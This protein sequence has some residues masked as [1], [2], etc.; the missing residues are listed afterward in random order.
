MLGWLDRRLHTA[1]ERHLSAA[2][3]E[4]P[5]HVAVI[6]DGNRRY[7]RK[8][9]E[10]PEAG[11]HAGA[12]TTEDMLS[13]CREV[14]VE[15]LTFYAFSTENFD[16]PPAQREALFDLFETKLREFADADRVHEEGVC[17]RGIGER[18]RLPTRV[19]AALRYAESRTEDYDRFTL[20]VALAYG[21]RSAM[22]SAARTVASDVAEGAI[23]PSE[24]DVE[25]V[26]ERLYDRPLRDVDLIVRTGG[27]ERT[28][29]FLP[30][31]A[32]GNE[33][34][35]YFCA[36]YWPEFSRI[37]FLR[38]L[39]TYEAREASWRRDR[40]RRALALL[41]AVGDAE[42]AEA[43]SILAR[44]RDAVPGDELPVG[45]RDVDSGE[46]SEPDP[47]AD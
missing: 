40:A 4:P 5:T 24:V 39:R 38:G 47:A 26:E 14:G 6:Q 20:N 23:E 21:G 12:Q 30:W 3:D 29:N 18:E 42:L 28:S 27:D 31:H 46:L 44:F 11:H 13:W 9:G 2:I 43:R 36:P 32:S 1:Y 33:A 17:I 25:T 8:Q 19:R 45:E 34:A 10:T 7:A 22:L 37:D 41:R 35:V 16:R 15:E